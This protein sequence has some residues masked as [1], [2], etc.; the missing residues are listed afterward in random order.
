MNKT[1]A[2][3]RSVQDQLLHHKIMNA[4]FRSRDSEMKLSSRSIYALKH[5]LHV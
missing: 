4:I 2:T 3:Q 1:S 5:D